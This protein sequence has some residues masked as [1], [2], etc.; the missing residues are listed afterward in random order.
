M[1]LR[2]K[3]LALVFSV[4]FLNNVCGQENNEKTNITGYATLN[5]TTYSFAPRWTFGYTHAIN[6]RWL[7]GTEVGF[8]RKAIAYGID[9]DTKRITN[10][11]K[12]FEIRPQLYYTFTQNPKIR[13]Y[14]S[15]ELFYIN[16]K[17]QFI[18]GEIEYNNRSEDYYEVRYDQADYKRI[19]TGVVFNFGF[20][21]NVWRNFGLN[22]VLGVGVRNRNVTYSNIINGQ[23]INPNQDDDHF[24]FGTK[25]YLKDAGNNFGFEFNLKL[26]L[27]YRF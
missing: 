13:T 17:D 2:L 21:K 20:Y 27:Y 16:H 1:S 6:S 3:V 19:K 10:N 18:N 8:G 24:N 23:I 22:P 11:Y 14:I 5:I 25:R 4:C 15:A 12:L 7:L 9:R 26:R